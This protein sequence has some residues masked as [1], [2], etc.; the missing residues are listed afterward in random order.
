MEEKRVTKKYDYGKFRKLI[1]DEFGG[2]S[3]TYISAQAGVSR[4]SFFK[5]INGGTPDGPSNKSWN[6]LLAF[7][8]KKGIYVRRSD[9]YYDENER[10][11]TTVSEPAATYHTKDAL[12]SKLMNDNLEMRKVIQEKNDLIARQNAGIAEL[13]A[14][15]AELKKQLR[16]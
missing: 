8:E 16:K 3:Y 9:F 2:D 5:W 11:E 12:I 10:A 13:K 15:I 6:S 4:S 7:F 1:D 14:T